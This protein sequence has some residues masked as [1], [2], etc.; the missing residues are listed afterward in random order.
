[1]ER[2]LVGVDG[3]PAADDALGWSAD[4]AG[5]AGLELVAVRVFVPPQAE[6]PP[7][8]DARLHERQ[9]DELD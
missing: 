9:R 5:R 3:S 2:I 7:D 6:L 8:E 1:M 4:I